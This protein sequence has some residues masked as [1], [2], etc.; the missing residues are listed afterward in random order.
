MSENIRLTYIPYSSMDEGFYQSIVEIAECSDCMANPFILYNNELDINVENLDSIIN[1]Y[2][3]YIDA[4]E[5]YD[6]IA[7]IAKNA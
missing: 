3:E 2:T 7:E 1:K 5:L 4:D 6:K